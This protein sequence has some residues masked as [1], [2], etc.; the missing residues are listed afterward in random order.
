LEYFYDNLTASSACDGHES[1]GLRLL[2]HQMMDAVGKK[3][4]VHVI[5]FSPKAAPQ[6][7]SADF[8]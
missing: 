4:A 2:I 8:K 5:I 1:G 6:T 3:Y 7:G